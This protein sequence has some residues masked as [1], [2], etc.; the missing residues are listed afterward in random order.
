MTRIFN[1]LFLT[2]ALLSTSSFALSD[3]CERQKGA[4]KSLK[5]KCRS[6]K[7]NNKAKFKKCIKKHKKKLAAFKTRCADKNLDAQVNNF[8]ITDISN[9]QVIH[10]GQRSNLSVSTNINENV[11]YQWFLAGN[12][13]PDATSS[14]YQTEILSQPTKLEYSVVAS[15]DGSD[16][17]SEA[18]YVSVEYPTSKLLTISGKLKTS[19]LESVSFEKVDLIVELF[20]DKTDGNVIYTESFLESNSQA[21][22]LNGG[23]FT[24]R[25]GQGT[26][27]D[28]LHTVVAGNA[29]LYAAFK[30]VHSGVTEILAPR[31]PITSTPYALASNIP[32]IYGDGNPVSNSANLGTHYINKLNAETWV[33]SQSGWINISR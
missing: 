8:Q 2:V 3:A 5:K 9:D 10:I 1:L 11:T 32:I 19:S 31:I 26:T 27:S 23:N 21:V 25:L 24:V 28:D 29:S 17:S 6:F 20:S 4:L 12:L 14:S 33:Y 7:A 22:D 18:I 30:V 13:I 16:I 15:F